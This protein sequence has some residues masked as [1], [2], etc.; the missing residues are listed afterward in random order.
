MYHFLPAPG[1]SNMWGDDFIGLIFPRICSSCGN[2]L[3]KHEHVLCDTCHYHLP[4]TNFHLQSDNPVTRIFQG[5]VDILSATSYLLFNKGSKV[6]GLIHA[7]KYRGRKDIGIFLGEEFGKILRECPPFSSSGI[8]IPV[9][10][11]RKKYKKR[12]Y[13]QSEQFAIGLSSSMGIPYTVQFLLRKN[14]TETQTHKSRFVR[15]EN[16]NDIFYLEDPGKLAGSTILLVDDV[17]TTGATLESCISKLSLIPSVSI[18][19]ATIAY[20]RL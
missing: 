2:S 5:R 8:I 4:R 20:T 13:N 19:V 11:H 3:W 7:L 18:S 1:L 17:V 12:G 10:L 16:V 14:E 6:Q 15:W 9:P